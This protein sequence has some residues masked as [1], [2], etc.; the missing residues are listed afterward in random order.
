MRRLFFFWRRSKF[1]DEL[2][3]ELEFHLEELTAEHRASGMSEDEARHRAF[4]KL[5]NRQGVKQA[6]RESL[7][8]APLEHAARDFS[9]GVRSLHKAG[10]LNLMTV[11]ALAL[12]VG[13][14]TIIFSVMYNGVLH[15]FPYR[16]ADR[17]VT[18]RIDDPRVAGHGV[19][20]EFGLDEIA[21]FRKDN[22]S[23]EDI[24]GYG[25]WYLTY[26]HEHSAEVLHGGALT[27]NAMEFFGVQP[28][29]GRGISDTDS[30]PGAPSVVLLNYR[31]W[32]KQ[33][34][35]NK[36]VLGTQMMLDAR[37]RTIVGVMPPRFQL[38]GAELWLPAAWNTNRVFEQNEPR[39]FWATAIL[40]R[41]INPRTAT[42]DLNVIAKSLARISPKNYPDRFTI[43]I[44]PLSDAVVADFKV[45]LLVMAAAVVLLLLLSCSNAAAL[46]LVR[47]SARVK[48]MAMR[49]ALGASRGRLVR[50]S[51]VES[52]VLAVSGCAAGCTI[53]WL[54]LHIV[55][56]QLFNSFTQIPWEAS[57]SLNTPS[58]VFA[59]T[60]SLFSTLLAGLAPAFYAA[61]SSLQPQLGGTGV[62]V[63]S[64]SVGA[65]FRSI[66]VV[67]QVGL[68]V[69]LLVCAGLTV[70]GFLALTHSDLGVNTSNVFEGAVHFPKGRYESAEAKHEYLDKLLTRLAL[71]PGVINVAEFVGSPVIGGPSSDVTIP[72]K[73][74]AEKWPT[75]FEACNDGYFSTLGLRLLRGRL[76]SPE[77]IASARRV[78]VINR[79]MVSR[80]FGNEN[81]LGNR[82]R[83][84]ILDELPGTPHGAYFEIVGVVSDFKNQGLLD[85]TMPEAF[86]PYSF[87]GFGDR[88]IAV[89]TA[90][91]PLGVEESLR[92]V[93]WELDPDVVLSES[94]TLDNFINR[95]FYAKPRFTLICLTVCA[96]VGLVLAVIGIFSVMAYSVSLLT[97]E[98]GVRI[99]LGAQSSTVLLMVLRTG[100]KLVGTGIVLGFGGA[101]LV[102]PVVFRS[103][104]NI[105]ALDTVTA[106]TSTG[107]LLAAGLL[108]CYLPAL[109]ATRVDPT[110][111]LRYE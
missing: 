4:L 30:R 36:A 40:K 24:V 9:F 19:R 46:L 94:T 58:L 74:H 45:T 50:Q 29:F 79:K 6:C 66:L 53:A 101:L 78:A 51:L 34:L 47:A 54:G 33:F 13:F 31:F 75:M 21:A 37:A 88:G 42:A 86:V 109:R 111:A 77:D 67:C 12:G 110:T 39:S 11:L 87:S 65:R 82:V 106:L 108:A 18:L 93:L 104:S 52:L 3:E 76:L 14:S 59:L 80:Y 68:S 41:G 5:G 107:V 63:N 20:Y 22:R 97:H 48:E 27:P 25:S 61:G 62:G 26:A 7:W 16:G 8:I 55:T 89:H 38:V 99:A 56:T 84:N 17:L 43:C 73:P 49:V 10:G 32:K 28:L 70:R 60:I 71:L 35:G 102:A 44:T 2:D 83:F 57:I 91:K 15:P 103:L 95:E 92:R 81:P 23:F 85:A 90:M 72:G 64:R 100:M 96:L 69:V 105:S 1:N 98:V